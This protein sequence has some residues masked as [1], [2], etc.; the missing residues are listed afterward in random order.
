MKFLANEN[1]PI[2]SVTILLEEGIDIISVINECPSVADEDVMKLAIKENRT[3]LTFDRD[4]GELIYKHGYKP[5][6]GVIYFR[7]KSFNPEDPAHIVMELIQRK[8]ISFEK[9]F[10]VIDDISIRQRKI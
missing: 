9:L 6:A 7:I 8:D 1:V 3:I 5:M 4:Y 10:T 2:K